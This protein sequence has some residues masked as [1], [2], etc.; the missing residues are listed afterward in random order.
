[1]TFR[2]VSYEDEIN[3]VIDTMQYLSVRFVWQDSNRTRLLG[4]G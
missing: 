1:M 4:M 3:G 2:L